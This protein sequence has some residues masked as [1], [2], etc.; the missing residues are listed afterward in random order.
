MVTMRSWQ[1][2]FLFLW[3]IP[4]CKAQHFTLTGRVESTQGRGLPL[5]T[6]SVREQGRIVVTDM[7]GSFTLTL[8][9]ADSV[10]IH[11]TCLGFEPRKKVLLHPRGKQRLV[12]ILRPTTHEIGEVDVTA[13]R[14]NTGGQ[15]TLDTK[16]LT[17]VP[18]AGGHAVEALVQSEAGVSAPNELSAQYNVRGGAFEENNVYVNGVEIYRP[19]LARDVGQ[20]GIS[21]LN[22]DMISKLSFSA[23][24][25]EAKYGDKL[26]SV[27][28]IDYKHLMPIESK[29]YK[30]GRVT[31]SLLGADAY[32]GIGTKRLSWLNAL[33]YKTTRTLLNTLDTGGEYRPEYWDY[34]TYLTYFF[35]SRWHIS[36]LGNI[37]STLFAFYPTSRETTFGT[38]QAANA[39]KVYFDGIE[40][41][42]FST[43]SG[44][45]TLHYAPSKVTQVTLNTAVFS[46]EERENYDIE[47]Q[48]WL[49]SSGAEEP[50]AV[51]SY[52]NHARHA[53]SARLCSTYLSLSHR[54]KGHHME[55]GLTW[56]VQ[57]ING[58]DSEYEMRDSAGY[59]LPR[60]A[61]APRPVYGIRGRNRLYNTR[62]E[63]YL[64]DTYRF[65]SSGNREKPDSRTLYT[66]RYGV[67]MARNTFNDETTISPRASIGIIPAVAPDVTLRF[68]LGLY[69]QP[70]LYKE[71]RDTVSHQRITTVMLNAKAK[72]QQL[73]MSVLGADYQFKV[74]N[75][76]FSFTAEVYGKWLQRLVPYTMDNVKTTYLGSKTG[77]GWAVGVDLKLYGEFVPGTDS[78]ITLSFMKT[79]MKVSGFNMPLP[80]ERRYAINLFFTDYFPGTDRWKML[81]RGAFA[82]GLPFF[83]PGKG[84]T[85]GGLRAP[86]Y[87][88]ADIGLSYRLTSNRLLQTGKPIRS[89]W[90]GTDCLN[91][92]G[93]NNVASYYWV[94][95]LEGEQYAVPNYLTGRQFNVKLSVEF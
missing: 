45:L 33:R 32:V 13:R 46:S 42:V 79:R 25:F 88:R 58:T 56:K 92:F 91:L 63:A 94:N 53:L 61:A 54:Y 1:L 66:L 87:K 74:N 90:I 21:V 36:F 38:A 20:E 83:P 5:S 71:L 16:H 7:N 15:Q 11:F 75:R 12:V 34:Q 8:A 39:F 50:L 57:H 4:C 70:P 17:N 49:T 44:V 9:E 2:F 19:L 80:S 69:H 30:E 47:G 28:D 43:L 81:L 77:T 14:R 24:G 85:E 55:A 95:S 6:V 3:A 60:E 41:D 62:W 37:N 23:G 73:W 67:R 65:L 59:T 51:G 52:F 40:R 18:V 84:L 68:A 64:Q 29:L 82:D 72:S 31:L 48:Y 10:V 76:P 22:P 86:A 78:W 27:L 89:I 93:M 35:N 26:S